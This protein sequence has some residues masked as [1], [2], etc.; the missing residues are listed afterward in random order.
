MTKRLLVLI[1][2]VVAA[3]VIRLQTRVEAVSSAGS[4]ASIPMSVGEWQGRPAARF[5]PEVVAAL[6]VKQYIHRTYSLA[7][8]RMAD[9]YLGYH[10]SQSQGTAIHSPMNCMPGAGWEAERIERIPFAGG[11]ARRVVIR[12]GTERMLVIYWYHT[13]TRIEGEEY[14]GR[15]YSVLDA[16][17]YGRN[18]AALVRVSVPMDGGAD[19]EARA[20]AAARDLAEKLAPAVGTTLY[21]APPAA[22]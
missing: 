14:R 22:S 8:G 1:V 19:A 13:A 15:F 21:S 16:M 6:G 7:D 18:D 4:L 12:K 11:T 9:L 3:G 20:A 10:A 17:R 2:L 5:T